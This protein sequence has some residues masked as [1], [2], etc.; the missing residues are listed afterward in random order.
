MWTVGEELT[1]ESQRLTS[2]AATFTPDRA[3]EL[4]GFRSQDNIVEQLPT[5]IDA[6]PGEFIEE[7]SE[8]HIWDNAALKDTN[9]PIIDGDS[10]TSSAGRFKRFGVSQEGQAFFLDFGTRIPANRIVFFP[11]LEGSDDETLNTNVT[12]VRL[13]FIWYPLKY[14]TRP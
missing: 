2:T 1:W 13:G 11:R 14:D 8:A 7:R 9:I 6:V 10:N 5:W 12:T 4:L 3:I